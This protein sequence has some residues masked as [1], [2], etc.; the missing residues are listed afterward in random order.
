MYYNCYIWQIANGIFG[1]VSTS[2][3][4]TRA[5]FKLSWLGPYVK[6]LN[7]IN[8]FSTLKT[9]LTQGP[10]LALPKFSL[11]FKL[12]I[13]ASGMGTRGTQNKHPIAKKYHLSCKSN[14]VMCEYYMPLTEVVAKFRF[15]LLDY[16]LQSSQNGLHAKEG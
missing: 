11:L 16:K 6:V 8:L 2:G 4:R 12:E 9:P 1:T 15:Y 3:I 10:L 14:K 7:N 5:R 13:D